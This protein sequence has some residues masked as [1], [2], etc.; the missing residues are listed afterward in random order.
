MTITNLSKIN[1]LVSEFRLPVILASDVVDV[2]VIMRMSLS[3]RNEWKAFSVSSCSYKKIRFFEKLLTE[4]LEDYQTCD[5]RCSFCG[6]NS[7]LFR[8]EVNHLSRC[9]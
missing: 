3:H 9:Q 1:C 6:L 8:V 7:N 5:D 4:I 2:V